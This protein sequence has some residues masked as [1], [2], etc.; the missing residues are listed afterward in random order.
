[1]I[2]SV[3]AMQIGKKGVKGPAQKARQTVAIVK[4]QG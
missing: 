1:L 3:T 2:A 4:L